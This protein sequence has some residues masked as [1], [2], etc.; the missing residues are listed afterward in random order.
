M[1]ISHKNVLVGLGIGGLVVG[2]AVIFGWFSLRMSPNNWMFSF[3]LNLDP[4]EA[5]MKTPI[6]PISN[7]PTL[8]GSPMIH[9]PCGPT[10]NCVEMIPA[11]IRLGCAPWD[12][13]TTEITFKYEGSDFT[14]SIF[15]EGQT[16][17]RSGKNVAIKKDTS[18]T[19]P[20]AHMSVRL[21]DFDFS[22]SNS[23]SHFPCQFFGE[24]EMVIQNP[25]GVFHADEDMQLNIIIRGKMVWVKTHWEKNRPLQVC[26]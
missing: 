24:G 8:P 19:G 1:G 23:K 18:G 12:G 26:G 22:V 2:T 11:T 5:P 13:L 25:L 6:T 7:V 14:A 9:T 4:S 10:E 15:G 3:A 21:C 17:F 16:L 20:D